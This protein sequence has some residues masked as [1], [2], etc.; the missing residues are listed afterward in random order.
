MARFQCAAVLF[1]LDGVLV[2][3]TRSVARQWRIWAKE[4]K[5]DASEIL[6]IAH[7][8]RSVEVI[9]RVAPNLVAEREAKKIEAREAADT[10]G[11]RVMPGAQELLNRI[12]EGRW[13]VVT[14]GAR[15]L[16]RSR[17]QLAKLPIP[18]VLVSAE[19]VVN[20][21]PCAEPYLN[22]AQ[23][24]GVRPDQCLVIEDA[25]AGIEAAHA[26]GMKV[27]ALASTYAE[28]DL[29][30]ADA[31]VNRLRQIQITSDG[32]GRGSTFRVWVR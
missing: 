19:D 18:T 2:D 16:A 27:I 31:V 26:G 9:Q 3:S 21:K 14:S 1:D 12:P 28:P 32:S 6:E 24:L 17:L 23:L 11:V 20:G 10:D 8:R 13:C 30:A 7:G 4:N 29:H 25:P 5:L 15:N 22:G